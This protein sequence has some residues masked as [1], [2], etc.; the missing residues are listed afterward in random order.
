MTESD[1]VFGGSIPEIYDTYLVPLIFQSFA[2]DLAE[3]VGNLSPNS[4]LETAAGS[5]VVTRALA[6]RLSSGARYVVTDLNPA[7]L[8]RASSEQEAA[9]SIEW[10]QAD[11]LAL[12]FDEDS[13][14]VICCQFGVMFF[15]DRVAGYA[16]ALRVLRTGGRFIF[17]IWDRIEENE[18]AQTVEDAVAEAFPNDPPRFL[19][20]YGY[21]D[22]DLVQNELRQAGFTGVSTVTVRETSS[23]PSPRHPAIAFCQGSPLRNEI[24]QRDVAALSSVTD[25]VA[26]AI[27]K[28]FG[29]G[30]VVGALQ[31]QVIVAES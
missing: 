13:F 1:S 10:R 6:P 14:D 19:S 23:A 11:A 16:E 24:E 21:H 28:R 18:F 31:G 4:V 3:R 17:N 12:P 15:P 30:E 7:M 9:D 29:P 22:L 5:G 26:E 20:A 8:D 25:R 2:E 27:A